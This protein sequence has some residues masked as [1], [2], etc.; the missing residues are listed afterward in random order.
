MAAGEVEVVR[1]AREAMKRDDARAMAGLA[2]ADYGFE[3][4]SARPNAGVYRGLETVMSCSREFNDTWETF[5]VEEQQLR[6]RGD[7][8]VIPGGVKAKGKASGVALETAVAYVHTLR[9]GELARTQVFFDHAQAL[10][11]SGLART[12]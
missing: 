2:H 8:V 9:A 4:T 1:S 10:E 12:A 11:A 3:T 5:V 6:H 7:T